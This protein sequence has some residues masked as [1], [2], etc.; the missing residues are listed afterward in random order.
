MPH[1]SSST[2]NLADMFDIS[3]SVS[4]YWLAFETEEFQIGRHSNPTTLRGHV[5]IAQIRSLNN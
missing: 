3:L 2:C 5:L 4:P 1:P